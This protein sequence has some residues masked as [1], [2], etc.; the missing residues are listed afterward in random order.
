M[1]TPRRPGEVTYKRMRTSVQLVGAVGI[2]DPHAL[3]RRVMERWGAYNLDVVL[4]NDW[5]LADN[6]DRG[7][8][9]IDI[10]GFVNGMIETVG[11][12]GL[13]TAVVV[14]A[15]PDSPFLPQENVY[16]HGG[17]FGFPPPVGHPN[18]FAG[19]MDANGCPNNFEAALRFQYPLPG[20]T[21]KYYPGGVPMDR[22]YLSAADVL[23]VFQCLAWLSVIG[24]K[25]FNIESIPATYPGGSCSLGRIRCH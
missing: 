25:E 10:V 4:D 8:Q 7:A 3:I 22:E 23:H 20:G 11:V 17:I 5:E 19:L 6:L 12:P 24:D 14:W 15:R 1:D 13:A 2:L 9:C 16:P 18:W 21:V